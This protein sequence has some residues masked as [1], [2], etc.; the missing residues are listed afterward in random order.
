VKE[1]L[2]RDSLASLLTERIQRGGAKAFAVSWN[3]EKEHY[4]IH[5]ADTRGITPTPL[6]ICALG[7]WNWLDKAI[8]LSMGEPRTWD[9]DYGRRNGLAKDGTCLVCERKFADIKSHMKRDRHAG[10]FRRMLK[11]AIHL[12][13][14]KNLTRTRSYG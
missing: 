2:F 10:N 11:R 6:A 7:N 12:L 8:R 13:S 5:L 3:S 4:Y 14:T 1:P 9:H